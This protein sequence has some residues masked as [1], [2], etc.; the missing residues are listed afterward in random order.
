MPSR[1]NSFGDLVREHGNIRLLEG[2]IA[3]ALRKP[4]HQL[5]CAGNE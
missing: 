2:A 1:S 4:P 3:Q 5:A